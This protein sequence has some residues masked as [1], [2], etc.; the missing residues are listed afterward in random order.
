[1]SA[2]VYFSSSV[3]SSDIYS[4]DISIF[5]ECFSDDTGDAKLDVVSEVTPTDAEFYPTYNDGFG[6]VPDPTEVGTGSPVYTELTTV[7]GTMH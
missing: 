5:T 1:M 3:T 4:S 7:I 2:K 6:T